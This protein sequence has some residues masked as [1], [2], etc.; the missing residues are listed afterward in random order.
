MLGG[1]TKSSQSQP[2]QKGTSR[3][4]QENPTALPWNLQPS[5]AENLEFKLACEAAQPIDHIS[6]END[7]SDVD[8]SLSTSDTC[9]L[10]PTNFD[11][12][13]QRQSIPPKT[14]RAPQ[15][16]QIQSGQ[17]NGK[18][19]ANGP[20]SNLAS[21]KS[22]P[23]NQGRRS[24]LFDS[25]SDSEPDPAPRTPKTRFSSRSSGHVASPSPTDQR[26]P[27][28]NLQRISLSPAAAKTSPARAVSDPPSAGPSAGS[29]GQRRGFRWAWAAEP[30]GAASAP[31]PSRPAEQSSL[32]SPDLADAAGAG[33]A[34]SSGGAPPRRPQ[35]ATPPPP[36]D[37]LSAGGG[38]GGGGGE[39]GW[40]LRRALTEAEEQLSAAKRRVQVLHGGGQTR[41]GE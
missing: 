32:N 33:T 25:S 17:S 27:R 21:Y 34:R 39:D 1:A 2:A 13:I 12:G 41:R 30:G 19:K 37:L 11:L 7:S 5:P 35:S 3:I 26:V 28:L 9:H 18:V 16:P 8:I 24:G 22:P 23:N 4:S 40:A 36:P 29:G 15:P 14:F 6:S 10:G 38:G 20:S 31:P